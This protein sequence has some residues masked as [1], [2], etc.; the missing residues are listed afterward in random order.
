MEYYGPVLPQL[1]AYALRRV[2]IIEAQ[3][4]RLLDIAA[5]AIRSAAQ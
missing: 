3:P 5:Y 2:N 1:V 4:G